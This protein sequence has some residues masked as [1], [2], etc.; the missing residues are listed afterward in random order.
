MLTIAVLGAN[1]FVGSR[2]VETFHLDGAAK[3]VPI[4]RG[5]SGLAR[6]SRFA[7]EARIADV[8]DGDAVAAALRGCDI[9]INAVLGPYNQIVAEPPVIYRAAEAAGVRRLVHISTASVHGQNPEPGTDET[10]P[11]QSNHAVPYN[12]AKVKA[13]RQFAALR[14]NGRV[15]LV[16]LRPGIVFG[17]RDVWISGIARRLS[18]GNAFLVDGGTGICNTAYIDNLV[19][20]VRLSLDAPVDGEA[21]LIGDN[22]TVTWAELH[23]WVA[24]ALVDCSPPRCLHDPPVRSAGRSWRDRLSGIPA[25]TAAMRKTPGPVKELARTSVRLLRAMASGAQESRRRQTFSDWAPP[26]D[27]GIGPVPLE[28]ALLHRCRYKFPL[29]KAR[30]LLGYEPI[31]S[32]EDGLI[33]TIRA[34][35]FAGY[36]VEPGFETRLTRA[37]KQLLRMTTAPIEPPAADAAAEKPVAATAA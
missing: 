2:I 6:L 9:V 12:N 15:E 8:L 37:R 21:F 34:L 25:W 31:V 3:V 16:V 7:L 24:T 26:E 29:A 4:V 1:G 14:R 30:R 22:E 27:A 33:R 11:L 28:T 20:A 36:V 18:E 19:H 35:A 17:P 10:S 32:V 23:R 5:F 13:E